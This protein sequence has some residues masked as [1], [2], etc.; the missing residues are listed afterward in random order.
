M[1]TETSRRTI[2]MVYGIAGDR[3]YWRL[4][5]FWGKRGRENSLYWRVRGYAEA[6]R[7]TPGGGKDFWNEVVIFTNKDQNL[8]KAHV[9]YLES[10]LVRRTKEAKRYELDNGNNPSAASLAP[11]EK[12]PMNEFIENMRLVLGALGYRILEPVS[13]YR[14]SDKRSENAGMQTKSNSADE[15]GEDLDTVFTFNPGNAKAEGKLT[16][17]G[18]LVHEGS[19]ASPDNAESLHDTYVRAREQ[20]M[21]S[22]RLN[23]DHGIYRFTEDVLCSSPTYAASVVAGSVRSGPR[24]WKD[25]DGKSIRDR[26]QAVKAALSGGN[27]SDVDAAE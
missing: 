17:E 25:D 12:A 20:L 1:S 21:D 3:E 13:D 5:S 4:F 19:T 10:K 27:R 8:T 23:E 24:V 2:G 22:G 7:P 18:F 9:K 26:E 11:A 16:D 15:L 14:A 6:N